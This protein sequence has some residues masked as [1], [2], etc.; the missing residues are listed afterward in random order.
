MAN[1]HVKLLDVVALTEDLPASGLIRGQVG[2]I[3]EVHTEDA[4]EVEFCDD[5]G[6]TYALLT[7]HAPQLMMLHH[8]P[9]EAA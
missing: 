1:Q 7:L 9:V 8:T 4:F 5:D 6:V 2:T 3:V